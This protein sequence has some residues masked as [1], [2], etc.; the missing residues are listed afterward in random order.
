M[1]LLKYALVNYPAKLPLQ[2]HTQRISL[3]L[4]SA[5]SDAAFS[6]A[7]MAEIGISMEAQI[8]M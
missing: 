6:T 8:A 3:W 2:N 1:K 4:S 7:C 5:A